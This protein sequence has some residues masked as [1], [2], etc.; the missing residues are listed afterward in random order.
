MRLLIF[1]LCSLALAFDGYDLVVYGTTIKALRDEWGISAAQ[2]GTIGSAALVGMLVGALLVG[3]LTDRWGRRRTFLFSVAW[4]SVL[5]AATAAATSPDMFLVLRFLA[6][7]GLGGLMPTAA[8]LTIEYATEKHRAFTYAAMQSGYA[9]GGILAAAL[10]IPLL[11][12]AGWRVMYLI[13]A[14]PLVI[15]LPLAFRYLPESLE[16]LVSRGR[17]DEAKALAAKIGVPVPAPSEHSTGGV[18]TL[19]QPPYL[20]RTLLFWAASFCGLLLVY[21]LNTWLP[22][23]MRASGYPLGSALSFLLVFNLGSVFGALLGGRLSDRHG[24]KPVILGSFALA[25][26]CAAAL[27]ANPGQL[28]IYVLVGLSGYGTIG[29]MH[30]INAHVTRSYPAGVRATGIGWALGVGRLGAILGP[31]VGGVIIDSRF[32]AIWNFY[33]FAAVAVLGAIAVAAFP[34]TREL[35]GATS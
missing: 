3:T 21:G 13:G 11:P 31:T 7:I 32:G 22:E 17:H 35:A 4:F 6:G 29:T 19:I 2:A 14:A 15:I 5:M 25:A 8:T 30:L 10:A 26:V 9:I 24:A 1:V 16:Y 12:T 20:R 33:L 28:L 18:R 27:S 23:I 34:R